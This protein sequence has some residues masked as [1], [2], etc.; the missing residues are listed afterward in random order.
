[1][2]YYYKAKPID[3]STDFTVPK[4][5]N[6]T[7]TSSLNF[8]GTEAFYMHNHDIFELSVIT[9]GKMDMQVD[10]V[11][12]EASEGDIIVINPYELHSGKWYEGVECEYKTLT[13]NLNSLLFSGFGGMKSEIQNLLTSKYGFKNKISSSDSFA[14]EITN[15]IKQAYAAKSKTGAHNICTVITHTFAIFSLLFEHY[16]EELPLIER[17]NNKHFFKAVTV[18]LEENY[19]KKIS[20]ANISASLYM[21]ESQFCHIFKKY[22]NNSFSK[23]L[24]K[25]RVMKA[26]KEIRFEEK[27]LAEIARDVGFTSYQYFARAFKAHIGCSPSAYFN[28]QKEASKK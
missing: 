2:S 14:A 25:Y 20:T 28:L 17:K 27:S 24:C 1:M 8:K 16:Y 22:Y 6:Y 23:F 10:A 5:V 9:K 7:Y 13:C 21:S 11:I 19:Q 18:Y 3:N 4:I 15:H 12:Y 26:A